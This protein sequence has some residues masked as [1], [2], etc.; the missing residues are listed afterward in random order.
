MILVR[1]PSHLGCRYITWRAVLHIP[2]KPD[3]F[4]SWRQVLYGTREKSCRKLLGKA[5]AQ[6]LWVSIVKEMQKAWKQLQLTSTCASVFS[7][8]FLS[9]LIARRSFY[10]ETACHCICPRLGLDNDPLL[11]QQH[12]NTGGLQGPS[13]EAHSSSASR[14][15][16]CAAF[17]QH[18]S[19]RPF[20]FAGVSKA[21]AATGYQ[22]R[23]DQATYLR[24]ATHFAA[25][26]CLVWQMLTHSNSCPVQDHKTLFSL[27]TVHRSLANS[28]RRIIKICQ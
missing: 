12:T 10:C 20:F 21:L 25:T 4:Q 28:L 6:P 5:Y 16:C 2:C 1:E 13:W 14:L 3:T 9:N 23:R 19:S 8:E 11:F 24:Q 26:L 27:S 22:V 15:P 7:S 17:V 18:I